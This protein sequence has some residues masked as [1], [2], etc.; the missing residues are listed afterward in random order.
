MTVAPTTSVPPATT[1]AQSASTASNSSANG[2]DNT[3]ALNF[4]QNFNTFL[5][6]LTT[7]LKNQDPLNPTDTSQF[8]SQLV[9]F[10]EV[11]QQIKTNSQLS[12]IISDQSGGEAV[13]ALPF[14]GRT[15]EY[16]GNQTVLQ[17]G[18]ADFSYTLPT[19][20]A[21]ASIIVTDSNGSSVFSATVN[22]SAGQ[23]SFNW[24]GQTNT[25]Q[26]LP[27]GGTFTIQVVAADAKGKAITA[28]TTA[29]GTVTGVSVNNNTA[30]FNVSGVQVPLN[31]LV[32]IVNPQSTSSN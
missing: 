29:S 14:V 30:T 32:N 12:T 25:G 5:T 23:H 8:T 6:L 27:N 31:Q 18:Q 11:E 2:T 20:A 3:G 1:P 19:A 17:N 21:T 15:I 24:N 10:S 9:Q 4:T 16:N 26:Q 22:P 7:Q 13:S 28:T